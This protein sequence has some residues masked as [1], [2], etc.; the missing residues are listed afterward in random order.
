M[1]NLKHI[2]LDQGP[3]FLEMLEIYV[4]YLGLGTLRALIF[5]NRHIFRGETQHLYVRYCQNRAAIVIGITCSKMLLLTFPLLACSLKY[6]FL[7]E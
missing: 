2:G 5:S 3:V 4:R 6:V 1:G 7:T